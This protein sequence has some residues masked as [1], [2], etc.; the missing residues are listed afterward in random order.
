MDRRKIWRT[1]VLDHERTRADTKSELQIG[2]NGPVAAQECD[3]VMTTPLARER[4]P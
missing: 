4:P 2:E 3:Q 1:S